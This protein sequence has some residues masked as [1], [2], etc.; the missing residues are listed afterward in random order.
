MLVQSAR[1]AAGNLQVYHGI[2]E[3]V[4]RPAQPEVIQHGEAA[5]PKVWGR[6]KV[7]GTDEGSAYGTSARP[8]QEFEGARWESEAFAGCR[9][10]SKTSST[11][12]LR[13]RPKGTV[14]PSIVA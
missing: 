1:H 8:K 2:K 6:L 9:S 11:L 14:P 4:T 13:S 3:V 12:K 10:N 5:V 7:V